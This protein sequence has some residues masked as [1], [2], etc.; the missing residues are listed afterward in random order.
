MS[1]LPDDFEELIYELSICDGVV[2]AIGIYDN[3]LAKKLT[4]IGW[5]KKNVKGSYFGT[6]ELSNILRVIEIEGIKKLFEK[7]YNI[8]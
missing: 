5:I 7:N 1:L 6:T 8:L 2:S 4:K 3:T